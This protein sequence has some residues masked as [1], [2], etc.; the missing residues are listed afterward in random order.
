MSH[1]AAP[2]VT[3]K[4]QMYVALFA[5]QASRGL[6]LSA[7]ARETGIPTGTLSWWKK[8]IVRRESRRLASSRPE[9]VPV[10]VRDTIPPIADAGFEVLLPNGVRLRVPSAFDES[11]L[12]RLI[13]TLASAC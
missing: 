12:R 3:E 2:E 13:V 8:E 11:A 6:S 5:E 9:F 7:L 10:T 1:P 4:E